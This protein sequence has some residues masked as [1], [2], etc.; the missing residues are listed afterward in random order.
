M[1]AS[2]SHTR[3]DIH[4]S[5]LTGY[6]VPSSCLSVYALFGGLFIKLADRLFVPQRSKIPTLWTYTNLTAFSMVAKVDLHNGMI[7]FVLELPDTRVPVATGP[8]HTGL[9]TSRYCHV[10]NL[11][12]QSSVLHFTGVSPGCQVFSFL[13]EECVDNCCVTDRQEL[14]HTLASIV[15]S[16][17]HTPTGQC[18]CHVVQVVSFLVVH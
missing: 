10:V 12:P 15:V 5:S 11:S 13:L 4:L 14:S 16:F 7:E 8:S 2:S 9:P 3:T 1:Q 17:L 6:S 18:E